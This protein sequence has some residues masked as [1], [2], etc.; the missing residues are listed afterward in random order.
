MKRYLILEDGTVFSG[1]AFGADRETTG[2]VVFTTSMTGYQEVLTDPSYCG[3]IITF[4][5]PL[6]G[7]YGINR[8]DYES[9]KPATSGII[10]NE[11]AEFPNHHEGI[12]SLSSWLRAKDIPG[13][14]GI[15]TRKLTRK[16][17]QY[18]TMKGKFVNSVDNSDEIIAEINSMPVRTDQV[19]SVSTKTPYHLPNS[20]YRVVVVDFGVK[21]GMLRELSQRLCD[22]I[23]VPYHTS[24]AEIIRLQPDGVLLSNGPGDPKEVQSGVI[25]IQELLA[26]HI[27]IL[28]ICLGH[29]LL[30]LASGGDTEKLKFGHRGSNHPVKDLTTGKIALTSQNHGYAVTESSLAGTDLELTHVAVNDGTVEGLK[31]KVKPAFSIQYHP[32]ASPG[33]Q[34]SNPIFDDFMKMIKTTKKEGLMQNA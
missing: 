19:P 22:V 26:Q 25:M 28:G 24:A 17:R 3:Q 16:I 1:W 5:Y 15:D 2:E 7:N 27:P 13:L 12:Q 4:T 9:I 10:V 29:Q 11:H 8:S 21:T 23:V 31:H 33:P 32:E 14:Y 34:D 20:G 6:V 30:A 18:G